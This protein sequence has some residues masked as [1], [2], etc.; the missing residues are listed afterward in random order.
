MRL[1]IVLVAQQ[2]EAQAAF[3]ARTHHRVRQ[4]SRAD[5]ASATFGQHHHVL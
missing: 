2:R 3:L 1:G 5:A 4:Q